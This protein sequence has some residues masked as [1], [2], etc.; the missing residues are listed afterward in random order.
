MSKK[1]TANI[2]M[3]AVILVI[4]L[5]GILIAGN[6][7]GWFDGDSENAACLAEVRG[8]VTMERDGVAYHA[9]SG[10]LLRNGDKLT[11]DT[12]ASAAVSV[13]EDRISLNGG[14]NIEII[15]ADIEEISVRLLDGEVF[16]FSKNVMK[17]MLGDNELSVGNAVVGLSARSGA[18]SAAV[19]CGTVNGAGSGNVIEW[20]S[21]AEG[22]IRTLVINELN[23]FGI[24]QLRAA[25]ESFELCFTDEELDALEEA[26]NREAAV[27]VDGE[28]E[29][30]TAETESS[31]SEEPTSSAPS[32]SE[33]GVSN[34]TDSSSSAPSEVESEVP[35]AT[36]APTST[37]EPT[38]T[39]E[40]KLTCT[41]T[42]RCDSILNNWD[43]LDPAKAGY[44]PSG[45]WILYQATVEFTEGETVFDVL[46]RACSTYGI[47]LEYSWTPMYNSYYVEGINHLYEF[48]CGSESGWMYK[49]NGWFPNYGCSSYTLKGNENIV[50]CYTCKGLGADVG[51]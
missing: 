24:E 34:T 19:Y 18:Q 1:R 21:G 43:S 2:I 15:N 11:C 46:Q 41:V 30:S 23:E 28:G 10:E 31:V 4:M 8:I 36:A 29:E 38:A 39:P 3:T 12:G 51:A 14:A 5:V 26:R 7:R 33:Q 16:V 25:S 40:P 6:I 32:E 20:I 47:Q 17:L 49:V 44:V 50:W 45:G 22:E 35:E 42:I 13:G 9:K 48:D 27:T 37:P